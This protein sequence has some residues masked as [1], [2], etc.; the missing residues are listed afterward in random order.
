VSDDDDRSL[1]R[2]QDWLCRPDSFRL[3]QER[4]IAAN[5]QLDCVNSRTH[6]SSYAQVIES[7]RIEFC[8]GCDVVHHD[9]GVD[10]S[11]RAALTVATA[12][13]PGQYSSG[14]DPLSRPRLRE[15]TRA[16]AH[17]ALP[18]VGMPDLPVGVPNPT[19]GIADPTV[20][21]PSPTVEISDPTVR[22]PEATV[23][24]PNPTVGVHDLTIGV[25]DPIVRVLNSLLGTLD[26]SVRA[27]R[28]VW[29]ILDQPVSITRKPRFPADR[30]PFSR[31]NCRK[32]AV[33]FGL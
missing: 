27:L 12:L 1:A 24:I 28:P 19:F 26:P 23:G 7:R 2:Q 6:P 15:P 22:V 9:A 3:S 21:V 16:S 17:A 18:L 13:F 30:K 5:H 14:R 20:G 4:A 25:P 8:N 29:A 31:S 10:R 33:R 11:R 32:R